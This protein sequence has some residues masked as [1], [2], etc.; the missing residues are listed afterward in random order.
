MPASAHAG[1]SLAHRGPALDERT[2]VTDTRKVCREAGSLLLT[3][4]NNRCL[5]IYSLNMKNTLSEI[6]SCATY[7]L[8]LLLILAFAVLGSCLVPTGRRVGAAC[9]S[10]VEW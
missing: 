7:F 9:P 2:H 5:L 1:L 6:Q 10:G 8:A 4:V 3:R